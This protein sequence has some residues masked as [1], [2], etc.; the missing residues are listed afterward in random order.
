M[1]DTDVTRILSRIEQGNPD[2]TERLLPLVYE[3]LRKLAA[4]RM[5]LQDLENALQATALVHEAYLRL[6]HVQK[7]KTWETRGHFFAATAESMRRILIEQARK[8]AAVK[9]GGDF[10]KV[11]FDSA[12]IATSV[13]PES[14]LMIVEAIDKLAPEQA[15]APQIVNL[16]YFAGLPLEETA[17]ALGVSLR[18]AY[19]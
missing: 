7:A 5:S 15:I 3:E 10:R 8:K 13:S 18:S 16:R 14:L 19:P 2:A 11:D 6:V 12:Q 4:H 1:T 17:Q 9:R